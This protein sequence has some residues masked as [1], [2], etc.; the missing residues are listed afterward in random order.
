L[1]LYSLEVAAAPLKARLRESAQLIRADT[2]WM[3][4]AQ[5]GLQ[6]HWTSDS[7]PRHGPK[8][9]YA[10][11]VRDFPV[12]AFAR[13]VHGTGA[14]Y[15]ILTTSH[16]EYYFP[17]PIRSIDRVMPGRT[18]QRDLVRDWIDALA[19]YG[20]RLML[21]YHVGHDHYKEPDGWWARTRFDPRHPEPFLDHWCAIVSE[22]GQRY[23]QGLAGWF[24]DDGCVYYPLNPDFRQL[25]L[26]AKT[27]NPARLVCYN[28]WIWPRFTDFQEYFCG[29]G[30]D[31]LNVRQ[32]L[33]ADGTGIFTGGPHGGLQAH[34]NFIL[35]ENW[36]HGAPETPIAAPR[37][38]RGTF[39]R[40][41]VNAIACGIAPSLNLE[42]Y[43]DGT[44]SEQSQEY[45][46]AVKRAV[47]G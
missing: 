14:G 17:A 6:F 9:P 45:L 11:A 39:V 24:F 41:M 37:L 46:Y 10:E 43:Q 35:E 26:A 42:I 18:T 21:Y 13:T 31:F 34:T 44:V 28:P 2:T 30:Y 29:E 22:V 7:Q 23:G 3:R 15:V 20:I 33:P 19:R 32:H 1:E 47:N 12:E 8:K 40:E 16:R 25:T 5:Y 4:A 27:G 38:D 36:W